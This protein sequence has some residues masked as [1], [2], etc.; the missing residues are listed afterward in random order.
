MTRQLPS[1]LARRAAQ[2]VAVALVVSTLCFVMI[3][4]LPGDLAY[5]IAAGRYGYDL[6]DSRSAAAVRAELGLDRPMLA[7]LADW[8]A[9]AARLDLGASLVTSRPVLDEVRYYL[10]G[11][12]QLTVVAVGLAIVLGATAGV[13]AARRP[14][15]VIDR[16]TDTWV[17][18]VRALPPFLL[19]LLL[20]TVLS[21]QLGLLP[22]VGHGTASS[23]VLPATTLAVGLSGLIARVTRDAV[24]EVRSSEHVQFART[25]GLGGR[26]L[27]IRHVARNACVLVVPYVG[28]QVLILIEGVVVVESLFGWQGLG[29]ALV[30][31][32]FWRDVPMLQAT[33]LAL[34]LLVVTIN[35]GVDLLM[36]WLDP[37]PRKEAIAA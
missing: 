8:L 1:I 15:G 23:I 9:S 2:A 11:T 6:V 22:A 35:T 28:A 24:V 29:H 13:L 25:K 20:I 27:L 4:Q 37:R 14:G 10:A 32:V 12:L 36:A 21:V 5:R 7:Q 16:L 31:A 33:A 17:A 26:V 3:R 34:A 30:H 19:G 18:A